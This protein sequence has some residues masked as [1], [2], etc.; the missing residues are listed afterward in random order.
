MR[1]SI[2]VPLL[3][4][5]EQLPQL[6]EHLRSLLARD[7]CEVIFVDGGSDDGSAEFLSTAGLTVIAAQRGRAR[8]M[9]AGAEAAS[10]DCLLFLHADTRL[11]ENALENIERA[12]L[13]GNC[14][15][16][17]DVRISGNSIWFPLIATLI[18]WRSRISGIATGDQ[19]IFVRRDLFEELGGF[20]DQ[21]LMEDIALSGRLLELARPACIR[22][23]VT[24]SGRRWQKYGV[25]RTVLLMWR[26]RFDYWRGVS[27]EQLARRYD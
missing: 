21:P 15:G 19:A 18:N 23:R 5:R 2:V 26:L 3:N 6:I 17:F 1:F 20:A 27:A 11:P 13:R 10:G 4:E 12:L 16:R 9:N 25:L 22:A 24:T 8:Q 14:W 7:N